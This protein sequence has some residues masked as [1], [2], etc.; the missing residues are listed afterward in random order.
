MSHNTIPQM[1][2]VLR[3]RA[4]G[5]LT[6]GMSTRAA[7]REFKMNFSITSRCFVDLENLTVRPTGLP[8][9]HHVY[10][11]VWTSGLLMSTLNIV[12]HGGD[13]VWAG[14]IYQ[15]TQ[16][17][18]IDGNLNAQRY[19]NEILRTIVIYPPSLPHVSA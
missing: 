12:P 17:H 5:M 3:D 4:I 10:D 2:E 7:A 19:H 1:T 14:I 16:L 6:A 15:Q 11:V 8:T 9:T 13:M 18:F